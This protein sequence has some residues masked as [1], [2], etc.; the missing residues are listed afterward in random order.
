[1]INS[2]TKLRVNTSG[3]GSRELFET[4]KILQGPHKEYILNFPSLSQ[5]QL[6]A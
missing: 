3:F 6:L 2:G 5:A 4:N 1:V